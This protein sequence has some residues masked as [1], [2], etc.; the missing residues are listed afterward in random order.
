MA[1]ANKNAV[2]RYIPARLEAR[3]R[4][5]VTPYRGDG[6]DPRL[7]WLTL[8][9]PRPDVVPIAGVNAGDAIS[10]SNVG[11]FAAALLDWLSAAMDEA[12]ARAP[13]QDVG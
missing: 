2:M 5:F 9:D 6:D 4:L 10:P 11:A 12:S 1:E 13:R 7:E 3:A 8:I